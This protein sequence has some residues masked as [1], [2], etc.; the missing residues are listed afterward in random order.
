[1]WEGQGAM[2]CALPTTHAILNGCGFHPTVPVGKGKQAKSQGKVPRPAPVKG[3]LQPPILEELVPSRRLGFDN[4]HHPLP[5]HT[6]RCL[7]CIALA[8]QCHLPFFSAVT[9][10]PTPTPCMMCSN[11]WSHVYLK[12]LGNALLY[13]L[14]LSKCSSLAIKLVCLLTSVYASIFLFH[15]HSTT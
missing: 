3:H 8:L 1:M 9:L 10:G 2:T 11:P 14:A 13:A 5:V 12:P 4:L 15:M 6:F 7:L